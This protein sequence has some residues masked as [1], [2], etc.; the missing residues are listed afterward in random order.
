MVTLQPNWA[1]ANVPP[2]LTAEE[3]FT[4]V[5][6]ATECLGMGVEMELPSGRIGAVRKGA[7]SWTTSF[8]A[9]AAA[10]RKYHWDAK[11]MRT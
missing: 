5:A 4:L 1:F 10:S 9:Y 8:D 2:G 7:G 11:A 6:N 3:K